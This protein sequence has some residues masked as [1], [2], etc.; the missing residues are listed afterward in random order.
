MMRPSTSYEDANNTR[1]NFILKPPKMLG[2]PLLHIDQNVRVRQYLIA[3]RSNS[4]YSDCYSTYESSSSSRMQSL[5]LA[6]TTWTISM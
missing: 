6:C 4:F 3:D 1:T 5:L 2:S